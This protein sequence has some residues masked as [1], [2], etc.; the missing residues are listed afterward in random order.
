MFYHV[1]D[2][3]KDWQ[4][5]SANTM[6]IMQQLT[7][8]S[9]NQRVTAQGRSLGRIA[10][11]IITCL[12]EMTQ[13][14]GLATEAPA[15]NAPVPVKA[16]DII[17][18]YERAAGSLLTAIQEWQD[19]DLNKADDMYGEQWKRGFSLKVLLRHEIHHRAQMTIL[20]RQAGLAV[21]GMYGPSRE[22][23]SQFGAPPQE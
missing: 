23:W 16:Q 22:E 21:P 14:M 11:H 9:L 17:I 15:E 19:A 13:R 10:W 20:M 2:F 8:D 3:I 6:K 18:A 12:G 4:K 1:R 5:E 7:D